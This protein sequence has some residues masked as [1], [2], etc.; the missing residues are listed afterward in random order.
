MHSTNFAYGT[1]SMRIFYSHSI[2]LNFFFAFNVY[3]I[4]TFQMIECSKIAFHMQIA[5]LLSLVIKFQKTFIL[6]HI[7]LIP[8]N[9]LDMCIEITYQKPSLK[10]DI[11]KKT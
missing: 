1:F 5:K 2:P 4:T 6:F 10:R 8:I 9:T 11:E 3:L 7:Y